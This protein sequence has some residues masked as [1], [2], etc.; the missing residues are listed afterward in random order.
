M[1]VQARMRSHAL[2]LKELAQAEPDTQ[3]HP[4]VLGGTQSPP[5]LACCTLVDAALG[6]EALHEVH[7][8]G[9][10]GGVGGGVIRVE[11][12]HLQR[13][14]QIH[15]GAQHPGGQRRC[16]GASGGI[17]SSIRSS[18]LN[19]VRASLTASSFPG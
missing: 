13:R 6:V 2:A 12:G 3:Q 14:Q 19:W 8:G 17:S 7:Q 1:G 5:H 4:A 11:G 10:G 9:R 15:A 16:R 18:T